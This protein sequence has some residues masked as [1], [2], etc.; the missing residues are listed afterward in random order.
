T[1]LDH[2]N[3]DTEYAVQKRDNGDYLKLA[4][5]RVTNGRLTMEVP[6]SV[7]ATAVTAQLP[8]T[9]T[10]DVPQFSGTVDGARLTAVMPNGKRTQL[11]IGKAQV[12][13]EVHIDPDNIEVRGTIRVADIAARGLSASSAAGGAEIDSAR[14]VG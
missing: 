12:D 6:V 5:G 1:T 14:L 10:L 11:E 13:G 7:G 9:A 2:L 3:I 8:T 4:K